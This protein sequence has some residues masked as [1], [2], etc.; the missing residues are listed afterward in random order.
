MSV[1]QVQN[2][3][4]LRA[5]LK[6][7][8]AFGLNPNQWRLAR[9]QNPSAAKDS[10][11]IYHNEDRDFRMVGMWQRKITGQLSVSALSLDMF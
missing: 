7:L 10:F 11:A 5:I 9:V 6:K 3:R 1:E 8:S 4:L 2:F